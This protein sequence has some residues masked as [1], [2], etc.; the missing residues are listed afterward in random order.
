MEITVIDT[1]TCSA[2]PNP[3][4]NSVVEVAGVTLYRGWTSSLIMPRMPMEP[5]A[6]ATHLIFPEMLEDAPLLEDFW[7]AQPVLADADILVAHNAK[8]D[9]PLLV[10]SDLVELAFEKRWICTWR[11]AL[12]LLPE[13]SSFKNLSLCVEHGVFDHEF[14][15]EDALPHR[16]LFDAWQTT[17]LLELLLKKTGMGNHEDAVRCLI[18]LTTTPV[19]LT[20]FG[21]GKHSGQPLDE[22]PSSY[23]H[24]IRGQDFDEDVLHTATE[25][26]RQRGQLR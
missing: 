12:H 3:E 22:V 5:G 18:E 17:A 13:S 19:M 8:F 1:E 6:I 14:P 25:T 7:W 2:E 26:L 21:F 20:K 11:C 10:D 15:G 24:W 16:A 4:L 23:L 9:R